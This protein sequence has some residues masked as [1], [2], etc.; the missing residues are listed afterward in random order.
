MWGIHTNSHDYTVLEVEIKA[1]GGT[2]SSGFLTGLLTKRKKCASEL[3]DSRP[4]ERKAKK[5]TTLRVVT[6]QRCG[7]FHTLSEKPR[8][9]FQCRLTLH[10]TWGFYWMN[11]QISI[12]K[13]PGEVVF[14]L[15]RRSVGHWHRLAH[16]WNMG[17][18]E[19]NGTL[20][21]S[22]QELLLL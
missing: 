3:C 20:V 10:K 14:F 15:Y 4:C 17:Q 6:P 19:I 9:R 13:E 5:S 16:L 2:F 22:R 11:V 1:S 21:P 18:R 12:E 8:V 7:F